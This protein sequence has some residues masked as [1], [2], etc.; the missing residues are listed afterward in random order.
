[1][2]KLLSLAMA[3][4]MI[5]SM[6]TVAVFNANAETTTTVNGVSA[7][8]GDVVKVQVLVKSGSLWENFQGSTSYDSEGLTL[9][10]FD[11][12]VNTGSVIYNTGVKNA[13]FYNGTV[14]ND[15]YDFTTESVF[16][17][18][19]FTVTN[20]GN[21][22]TELNWDV[23]SD[24]NSNLLV[25][26]DEYDSED[27]SYRVITTVEKDSEN[28]E[29]TSTV[30]TSDEATTSTADEASSTTE[31]TTSEDLAESSTTITEPEIT[32]SQEITESVPEETSKESS[33][34]EETS[35][36]VE[37]ISSSVEETS[38]QEISESVPEETSKESSSVEETSS[39]V[40]ETSSS[41]EETSSS[42]K[43][44]ESV[45]EE[46]SKE[47]SS[48]EETSSS[49]EET[50]SSLEETSSSQEITDSIPEETSIEDSSVAE[51]SSSVEETSSSQEISDTVPEETSTVDDPANGNTTPIT[52]FPE[53]VPVSK[54]TLNTS[55]KTINVGHSYYLIAKVSP[56][57]ATVTDV[58]WSTSNAKIATVASNGKVSAKSVGT[59]TITATAK[60]GSGV[61]ATAKI[62]VKQPVKNVYIYRNNKNVTKGS[63]TLY[64]GSK[65]TLKTKVSPSNAS[66]KGVN[67]KS[68]K[69]KVATVSQK[70]VVKAASKG[71]AKIVATAK[72]G[73]RKS[74][75][76]NVTVKQRVT[77]V[78]LTKKATVKVGR[79][80]KLKAKVS[81]TNANN[82][83]L[84][85]TVNKKK[86]ATVTQK[87]VVK[88]KKA[89]KAIVKATAKDGSRKSA[90]CTVT[91]KKK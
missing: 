61:K 51:T 44:T 56:S 76:V 54:I 15:S 38:S 73:S 35:S 53:N 14:V 12:N 7:D 17:T 16:Y 75:Y 59:A 65:T 57:D 72:D 64:K 78:T 80:I 88:G 91:V 81:P 26:Q 85:W 30:A 24:I 66:V 45:P 83:K 4:I 2:K 58:V 84:K 86:I 62:T 25:F 50:S 70:G 87:G 77:K 29:P 34:V 41:V 5:T 31:I 33:S 39:S 28:E 37:E 90:K 20:E 3:L 89:G 43:I 1:M 18:A 27:F 79:K 49:V 21:Y 10:T 69:T 42:Q 48:V 40:E 55:A 74:A 32:S 22:T 82:K 52:T 71:S 60:D 46:T 19:E 13:I 67:W 9:D 63:I 47:S 11:L 23:V 68:N 8:V 6:S 36:S